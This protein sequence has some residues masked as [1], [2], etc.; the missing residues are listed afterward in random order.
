MPGDL[1]L[2]LPIDPIEAVQPVLPA[3]W[4]LQR[5]GD[6]VCMSPRPRVGHASVLGNLYGWAREELHH[7][8]PR[9]RGP[10]GWVFLLEPEI[11][12]GRDILVPDLAGWK[13][14]RFPS[15]PDAP[16]ITVAP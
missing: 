4:N 2:P 8:N 5:I 6:L 12:L 1:A 11:H 10:G 16:A 9:R 14:E 15:A 7:R 3:G 13:V